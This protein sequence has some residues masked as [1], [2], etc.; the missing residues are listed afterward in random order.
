MFSNYGRDASVLVASVRATTCVPAS[1]EAVIG[2]A[3]VVAASAIPPPRGANARPI[4][5]G[6]IPPRIRIPPPVIKIMKPSMPESIAME[7]APAEDE[8]PEM[9][10]P[11]EMGSMRQVSSVHKAGP[12]SEM[13]RMS[14]MR[15]MRKLKPMRRMRELGSVREIGAV[16]KMGPMR[17]LRCEVRSRHMRCGK[18]RRTPA[19]TGVEMACTNRPVAEMRTAARATADMG[20]TSGS[21][22]EMPS[23]T[24]TA[25][26]RRRN[27]HRRTAEGKRCN[28]SQYCFAHDRLPVFGPAS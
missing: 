6:I 12:M 14:E 27:R 28:N 26:T 19:G 20:C 23:S 1:I 16:R 7:M 3:A 13:R 15:A 11:C 17:E 18:V 2:H 4:T 24:R 21:A 22:A 9:R 10:F 5:V 25:A 8:V